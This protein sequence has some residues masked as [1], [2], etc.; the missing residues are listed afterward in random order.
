MLHHNLFIAWRPEYDLGIRVIDEQHRGIVST[1][2]SLYYGMQTKH[3][4]SMLVPIADMVFDYTRI[5]FEV[6]EEFLKVLDYP[7]VNEHC[8]LHDGL[9]CELSNIG[10]KSILHRD[11]HEF[12]DFLKRWW[13]E[14]ICEKDRLFRD[15]IY[16]KT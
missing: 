7:N 13:L 4:E 12:M 9:T 15:Y 16:K 10:R 11:P 5:H 1:I 3:G 6:E 14:H 8:L 2:N